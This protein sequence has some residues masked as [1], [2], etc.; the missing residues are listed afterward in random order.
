MKKADIGLIGIAVM[1]QA[2][3]LNM[4]SKGFTVAV[5]DMN[6]D[7]TVAGFISGRAEGKNI[8]GT[9]TLEELVSLSLIHI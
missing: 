2:L 4:E 3:A 1:G 8:I 6:P 5:Y 9:F 7:E